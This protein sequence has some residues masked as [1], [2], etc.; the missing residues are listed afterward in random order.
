MFWNEHFFKIE[1]IKVVLFHDL[2]N[3][4]NHVS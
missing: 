4:L 2:Y 3:L 1:A